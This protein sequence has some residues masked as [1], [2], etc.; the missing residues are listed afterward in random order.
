M[1]TYHSYRGLMAYNATYTSDDLDDIVVDALGTGGVAVIGF[2]TIIVILAVLV[3]F[4]KQANRI[5]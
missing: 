3:H 2:V 5:V 4:K 1:E